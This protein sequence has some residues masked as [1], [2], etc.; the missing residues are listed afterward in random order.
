MGPATRAPVYAYQEDDTAPATILVPSYYPDDGDHPFWP[1]RRCHS[2]SR[3]QHRPQRPPRP[4][5]SHDILP[6]ARNRPRRAARNQEAPAEPKD[7]SVLNIGGG[8]HRTVTS[9]LLGGPCQAMSQHFF[10]PSGPSTTLAMPQIRSGTSQDSM[11][12]MLGTA[13]TSSRPAR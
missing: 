8:V 13:S 5:G 6:G 10:L 4:R 2:P 3:R 7:H 9:Q 1:L 11:S 12:P